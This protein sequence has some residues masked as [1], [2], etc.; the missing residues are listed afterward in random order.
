MCTEIRTGGQMLFFDGRFKKDHV[1]DWGWDSDLEIETE[2][3]WDCLSSEHPQ[4]SMDE[5]A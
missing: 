5:A 4:L 3:P 2:R 1:V